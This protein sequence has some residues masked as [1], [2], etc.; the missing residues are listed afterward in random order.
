MN[1]IHRKAIAMGLITLI[2]TSTLACGKKNND[3]SDYGTEAVAS[4]EDADS[5][6]VKANEFGSLSDKLETERIDWQESFE[7]GG[8]KFNVKINYDVPDVGS[9]PIYTI[10]AVSDMQKREKDILDTLFGNDYEEVHEELIY[11]DKDVFAPDYPLK[12]HLYT[13]Y[14]IYSGDTIDPDVTEETVNSWTSFNGFDLH[15]YK[16]TYE[17]KE[18]YIIFSMNPE[19]YIFVMTLLPVD[20]KEFMEDD[21]VMEYYEYYGMEFMED[22]NGGHSELK[23]DSSNVC[24]KNRDKLLDEAAGFLNEK[25]DA[26]GTVALLAQYINIEDT[27]E[28]SS[29]DFENVLPD[30]DEA[31][32]AQLEFVKEDGSKYFD[33]YPFFISRESYG[34]PFLLTGSGLEQKDSISGGYEGYWIDICSKGIIYARLDEGFYYAEPSVNDTALL[35]FEAIKEALR[36]NV[37]QSFDT[38]KCSVTAVNFNT[39]DLVYYPVSNPDKQKEFTFVPAWDFSMSPYNIRVVINAV[40]GSLLY[41]GYE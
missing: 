10:E 17:N 16:G 4:Q 2:I 11:G 24:I 15:T 18:Y 40:D 36:E 30:E 1:K 28:S 13:E 38:S 22:E 32:I 31:I 14:Y 8:T 20:I 23:D 29:I 12:S 35:D 9:I 41:I 25:L 33:G 7:V 5:Q 26:F 21:S 3:I 39:L 27:P 6:E 34:L 37:K 19:A